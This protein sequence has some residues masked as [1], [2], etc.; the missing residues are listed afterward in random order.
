M[1]SYNNLFEFLQAHKTTKDKG[2]IT[3]TRI[4]DKTRNI[5][6]GSYS[7]PDE[8]LDLFYKLYSNHVFVKKQAE[9]LTEVQRKTDNIPLLV[10]FDFRYDPSIKDRQHDIEHI[11]G[12]CE[13]YI[14]AIQNIFN[15]EGS[16]DIKMPIYIYEKDNVNTTDERVT[17]DGIHMVFGIHAD[18]IQQQMIRNEVLTTISRVID[19]LELTNTYEDVLDEGIVK[20]HTNWQLYGSQKPNN[21]S[22]KLKKLFHIKFKDNDDFE[23]DEQSIRNIKPIQILNNSSARKCNLIHLDMKEEVQEQYDQLKKNTKVKVKRKINL[24][25]TQENIELNIHTL[26]TQFNAIQNEN[27]LDNMINIWFEQLPQNKYI[28]KE[29]HDFTLALPVSYYGPG[30]YNKWIRTGWALANTDPN[31]FLTWLKFSC[32]NGCRMTLR[33]PDGKFDWDNVNELYTMWCDFNI[34]GDDG[35]LTHRSIMYWCKQ[36]NEEEFKR[37]RNNTISYYLELNKESI[38]HHDVAT[39]IY[40][41]YKDRYRCAS[42]KGGGLWYEFKDNR[43]VEI[44]GGSSLRMNISTE[45]AH[46]YSDKAMEYMKKSMMFNH[47]DGEM[48]NGEDLDAKKKQIVECSNQYTA[49]FKQLRNS[50]YKRSVMSEVADIFYES[51]PKFLNNIDKNEYLLGFKNGVFDF[52]NKEFRL[53]LPEDYI[54]KSTDINYVKVDITKPNHKKIVD[55]INDFMDKLFPD[56]NLRRYMWEHMASVL[57]GKNH[58]QTFNIYNGC[59]RNGKS[60]LV[61]L[62][63]LALGEYKSVVPTS[64]VTSKRGGVG[65]LSSEIAQLKGVRYAVMQ[66]P[67]KNDQLNDGVMKELTGEDPITANPKFKDPITFIPQFKL[68]VCTNN[69]FDIKSDDD[70][71]WRR[72]RLCEFESKFDAVLKPSPENPYVFEPDLNLGEKF[73]RWKEIFMGMLVDIAVE[74]QG[75]VTDCD[76]VMLASNKYRQEQ[77]C[78]LQFFEEMIVQGDSTDMLKITVAK[79]EFKEWYGRNYSAKPPKAKELEDFLTKKLG[80]RTKARGWVGYKIMLDEP[81]YDDDDFNTDD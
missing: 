39:L 19:D 36:E 5:Y 35:N 81:D 59:G 38:E 49:I 26:H 9:Y 34:S 64:L 3:H 42:T 31:M 16:D 20:G 58:N 28:I 78:L 25:Q 60:K 73:K 8:E 2:N 53:G 41:Y 12:I 11:V 44:E 15:F 80:K 76:K 24:L 1:S 75:I 45:I 61:E 62:L 4:G 57:I 22:Y 79:D 13:V 54:T 37:V 23:C 70:G 40:Q 7:I 68:V 14:E 29:T 66:E 51:D 27:Q 46:L 67:S 52:E 6:A 71:T 47:R 77:D 43:W 50:N 18:H 72:I 17:K 55:E 65:Q 56:E 48:D 21:E 69:L 30:S 32:Q 74:K 63:S 33:G 10:D